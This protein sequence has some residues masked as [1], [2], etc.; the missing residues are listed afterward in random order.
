M[1]IEIVDLDFMGTEGI[2]ASFLLI[3][4]ESAAIVE[5]GP[6]TCIERLM[7][8]LEEHGVAPED[9]E[10]V[11]VT[12]IHLDHSGGAGNLAELLPNATFYVHEVG[13]P[14]LVDPSKLWKSSA[15]IYGD[16][17]EELWGEAR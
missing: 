5:T 10:Q 1:K 14:H 9:V 12:H 3:G 6:A 15:L 17:M 11:F 13:Y 2:I 16:R 8:G 7:R 4:E